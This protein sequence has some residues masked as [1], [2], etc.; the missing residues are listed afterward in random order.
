[1]QRQ[2]RAVVVF[3]LFIIV[4]CLEPQGFNATLTLGTKVFGV[5]LLNCTDI[6]TLSKQVKVVECEQRFEKIPIKQSAI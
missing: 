1:M 3:F 4:L 2:T 5:N 6:M